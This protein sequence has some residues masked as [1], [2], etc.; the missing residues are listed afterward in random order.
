MSAS[1]VRCL[2]SP[3]SATASAACPRQASEQDCLV[4]RRDFARHALDQRRG[5]D[6]PPDGGAVTDPRTV[7]H[8]RVVGERAVHA[9]ET[10]AADV[11]PAGYDDVRG[12][13]A[14]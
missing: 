11:A 6:V 2:P 12:D 7:P 10:V 1:A 9:Q 5:R 8:P 13:E 4:E 14:M 3:P